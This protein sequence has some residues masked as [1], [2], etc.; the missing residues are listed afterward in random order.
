MPWLLGE[1]VLSLV[2]EMMTLEARTLNLRA[3]AKMEN[4]YLLV[5][6]VKSAVNEDIQLTHAFEFIN[7]RFVESMDIS[8]VPATK[9]L[10]TSLSSV[11]NSHRAI[12]VFLDP[13]QNVKSA[14][15]RVTLQQT[16]FTEMRCLLD[17]HLVSFQLA[18]FVV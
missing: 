17:L 4:M 6:S 7:V 2:P 11:L 5:L 9:I 13:L 18:R 10:I 15:R 8:L 1:M 12:L 3:E 14:Q 16:A